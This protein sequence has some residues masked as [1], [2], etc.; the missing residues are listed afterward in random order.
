ME[1]RQ[2]NQ[3]VRKAEEIHSNNVV[4]STRFSGKVIENGNAGLTHLDP[5][6]SNQLCKNH[7]KQK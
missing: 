2:H 6:H 1:V 5:N 4:S 7:Q 3:K